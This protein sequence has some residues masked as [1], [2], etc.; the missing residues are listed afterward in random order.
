VTI[1]TAYGLIE[2]VRMLENTR[3]D[4]GCP[5]GAREGGRMRSGPPCGADHPET[6]DAWASLGGGP[7]FSTKSGP[8][9]CIPTAWL[10]KY[11][12]PCHQSSEMVCT[13]HN[14]TRP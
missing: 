6:T 4:K 3:V 14:L 2:A 11:G 9:S 13:L 5:H 12:A 1:A 8:N 10:G 7:S